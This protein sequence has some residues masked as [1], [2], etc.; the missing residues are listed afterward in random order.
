VRLDGDGGGLI[1]RRQHV[2]DRVKRRGGHDDVKAVLQ[3]RLA[4]Y[5]IPRE[6]RIVEALPSG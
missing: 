1:E 4:K 5:K 3:H 2:G 6:I